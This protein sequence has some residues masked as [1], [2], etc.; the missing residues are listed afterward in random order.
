MYTIQTNVLPVGSFVDLAVHNGN[1]GSGIILENP[2]TTNNGLY[3]IYCFEFEKI[4]RFYRFE[5]Y[6]IMVKHD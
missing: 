1:Y 4:E 5:I 2:D 6:P 3:K